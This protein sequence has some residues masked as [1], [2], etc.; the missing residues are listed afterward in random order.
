MQYDALILRAAERSEH[1]HDRHRRRGRSERGLPSVADKKPPPRLGTPERPQ[2]IRQRRFDRRQ[3][4]PGFTI[5][6]GHANSDAARIQRRVDPA[7]E[8]GESQLAG[9]CLPRKFP[10][11]IENDVT[12]PVRADT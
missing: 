7:Q 8:I 11:G 6:V 5:D 3:D 2:V 10:P 12:E 1:Q 9:H 4:I